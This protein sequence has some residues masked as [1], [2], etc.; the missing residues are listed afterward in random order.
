M[1]GV[2]IWQ[3]ALVVLSGAGFVVGLMEKEGKLTE[4]AILIG[5]GFGLVLL[6][7]AVNYVGSGISMI[8]KRSIGEILLF[9]RSP[10]GDILIPVAYVLIAIGTGS[11]VRRFALVLFG[12]GSAAE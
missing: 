8:P 2:G 9:H 6:D 12:R 4:R 1:T 11:L 10:P 3:Y 7:F 5:V